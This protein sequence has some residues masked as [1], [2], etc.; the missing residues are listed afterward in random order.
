MPTFSEVPTEEFVARFCARDIGGAHV[1]LQQSSADCAH[2]AAD[3]GQDFRPHGRVQHD[4]AKAGGG[5]PQ[6]INVHSAHRIVM[7]A[8]A[9]Q[10]R[11]SQPQP[12]HAL[13]L[14]PKWVKTI[15]FI[16]SNALM[17]MAVAMI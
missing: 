11:L 6:L 16:L 9:I 15:K 5:L 12:E 2:R 17:S 10:T 7:I 4:V 8:E 3:F 14:S 13:R 1:T